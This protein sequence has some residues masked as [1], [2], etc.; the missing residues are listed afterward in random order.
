MKT[1]LLHGGC[2]KCGSTNI[3]WYR[4]PY[5]GIGDINYILCRCRSCHHEWTETD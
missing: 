2:P 4:V 1:S 5:V 3:E